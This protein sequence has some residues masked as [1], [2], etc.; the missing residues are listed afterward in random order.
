MVPAQ[1]RWS[2]GVGRPS[3]LRKN[4]YSRSADPDTE[5]AAQ[6]K[7]GR[8]SPR[9]IRMPQTK[10]AKQPSSATTVAHARA[11]DDAQRLDRVTQTLEVAQKDLASIGGSVGT[12]VRDLR[13]D[14][15]RLLRDA[16]R[17][18]AKMRR[19]IQRDLDRLQNDV[20]SAA[21]SKSGST[22][23]SS[24]SGVARASSKSGS[25]R[26]SS[27]TANKRAPAKASG[28]RRTATARSKAT[29]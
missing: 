15:T 29:R 12:G 20:A 27:K 4:S 21:S 25:A 14:V 11:E 28:T 22:R 9:E 5:Y 18:L 23:A 7:A 19:A 10:R 26:G 16:R 6:A 13:R 3:R 1:A 2:I 8:R 24:K 17:D